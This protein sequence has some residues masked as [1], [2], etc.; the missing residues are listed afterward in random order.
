[1]RQASLE[2]SRYQLTS[3]AAAESDVTATILLPVSQRTLPSG[4]QKL[5]DVFGWAM[6]QI[7]VRTQLV[8]TEVFHDSLQALQS[9]TQAVP[10][11]M[12]GHPFP[13]D[14]Y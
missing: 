6:C 12:P 9:N 11:T 8:L 1:L 7:S 5:R 4:K 2:A 10:D 13:F 3:S 14:L